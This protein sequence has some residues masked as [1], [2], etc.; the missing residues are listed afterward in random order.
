M[1]FG[2]F[3]KKKKEEPHYDPTN[4]TIRD[5]RLGY[6]FDYELQTFEVV[7][8]YEYDWGD[9]DFSWEY[10]IESAKDTFYLS[11][12]EEGSLTGTV[13]QSILWGK[14]PDNVEEDI[15]KKGKPPRTILFNGKE[16]FRDEKSVG[17]WRDV[18]SMSS[19]ESTEYMCWDYYDESE[20]FTLCIEQYQDEGFSASLGI[21]EDASKFTN[22]LPNVN[23]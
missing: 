14:L 23:D 16:F 19:E 17:Y 9:N 4:I 20:K 11:V 22:I 1:P 6:I 5:L 15:L 21:V 7:G 13:S 12:D 10:K 18:H 8:E 3:K 2:F